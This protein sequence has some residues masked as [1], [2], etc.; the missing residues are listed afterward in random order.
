MIARLAFSTDG[1]C[2]RSFL[3]TWQA[4]RLPGRTSASLCKKKWITLFSLRP[5]SPRPVS[6][7]H[8]FASYTTARF[9]PA[10]FLMSV[11]IPASEI[12]GK[13]KTLS[14]FINTEKVFWLLSID[15]VASW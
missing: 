10:Q 13:K 4:D 11:K 14:L 5:G 8:G 7:R 9:A 3:V 1:M 15:L 2:V 12:W 6:S